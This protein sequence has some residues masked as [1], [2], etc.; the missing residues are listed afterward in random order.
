MLTWNGFSLNNGGST[1]IP[2]DTHYPI[3]T[4]SGF[5]F[6]MKDNAHIMLYDP[7]YD[8][9]KSYP[10]SYYIRP[11]GSACPIPNNYT[12]DFPAGVNS[13]YLSDEAWSATS[14]QPVGP[15]APQQQFC[16]DKFSTNS[17]YEIFQFDFWHQKTFSLKLPWAEHGNQPLEAPCRLPTD[18]FAF[19][20]G[21]NLSAFNLCPLD[22]PENQGWPVST[23]YP[24]RYVRT[25]F[26]NPKQDSPI[27]PFITAIKAACP[28]INGSGSLRYNWSTDYD[29][30]CT[31]Y[32]DW[33]N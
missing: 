17:I 9:I 24:D 1:L 6:G 33:Y 28:N 20:R 3:V 13:V 27:E 11:D 31:A 25:W 14:A 5:V 29:H 19:K 18:L 8:A 4:S 15:F 7:W 21:E 12:V 32:P 10:N 16:L 23:S 22:F 2:K 30:C 26:C